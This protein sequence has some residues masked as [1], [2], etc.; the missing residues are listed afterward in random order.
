M[1]RFAQGV[2]KVQNPQKYMGKRSP[3][4]RSSWELAFMRFCDNNIHILEWAS[5][6]IRIPYFNPMKGKKTTYVPDFLIAYKNK[7]GNRIVELIEIKP[8][9]QSIMEGKLNS[10]E[11]AVVAVNH[12]KWNAAALWCKQ[13]DI[14]FRVVTEE[15]MFKK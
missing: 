1:S 14:V 13:R 3:I 7:T 2:Y 11:R 9:K 15:Q 10:K 12:A 5:E 4:Y 6:T 8:K